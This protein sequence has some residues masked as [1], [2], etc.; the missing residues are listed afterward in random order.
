MVSDYRLKKNNS[1]F[2]SAVV[3][4]LYPG[5]SLFVKVVIYE[6]IVYE[7]LNWPT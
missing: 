7:G 3:F 2:L 1:V 4:L 6:F 5:S